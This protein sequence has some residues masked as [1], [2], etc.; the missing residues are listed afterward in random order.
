MSHDKVIHLTELSWR[1]HATDEQDRARLEN[2]IKDAIKTFKVKLGDLEYQP[3][4][5]RVRKI[6]MFY[7]PEILKGRDYKYA[8]VELFKDEDY[9]SLIRMKYIEI[10]GNVSRCLPNMTKQDIEKYFNNPEQNC[11]VQKI[12]KEWNH[13]DL[14]QYFAQFGSMYSVKV[15]KSYFWHGKREDYIGSLTSNNYELWKQTDY[16]IQH[17]GFGY[18][19]FRNHEDQ[20]KC[21]DTYKTTILNEVQTPKDLKILKFDPEVRQKQRE[22]SQQNLFV[23][24]FPVHWGELEL[25]AW[26]AKYGE[27]QSVFIQRDANGHSKRNGVVLFKHKPDAVKARDELN[28]VRI[29]G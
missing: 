2:L 4:D 24:G 29:P 15:S 16:E 25:Q 12:P 19:S 18:A 5:V 28:G 11:V 20:Q 21:L 9:K 13:Q 10:E 6:A 26:F 3:G 23:K 22:I 27:I 1:I 17:N 14:H 8:K 7:N